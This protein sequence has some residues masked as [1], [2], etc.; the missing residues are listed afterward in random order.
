MGEYGS[1]LWTG[2]KALPP[3]AHLALVSFV[4]HMIYGGS[5]GYHHDEVYFAATGRRWE[6]GYVDNPPLVPW[7]GA[8]SE[9]LFGG[10]LR[11]LRLFPALATSAAI[12]LTGSLCRRLGG[13]TFAQGIAALAVLV[14]PVYLRTGNLLCIPAFE[15]LYWVAAS[16]LVVRIIDEERPRLWMWIGLIAGV[17]L[18]TKH[19]MLFF[20]FGLVIGLLMTPERKQFKSAWLWAGGAIA[21]LVFS[22]NLMWQIQN[23]W[24]TL[25]FI[26]G[27]NANTMS[28]ISKVEFLLGQLIYE[29]IFSAPIWIM[30]IVFF[31]TE[32]GRR[33]RD[34]GW[35]YITV[36]AFLLAVGSKIYYLAPAYLALFAGGAVQLEAWLNARSGRNLKPAFVALLVFGGL[37]LAP[38][39][40]PMLPIDMTDR[41]VKVATFGAIKNAHELTGDL[42][43]QFGWEELVQLTREAYDGIPDAE[44]DGTI[45]LTFS[46]AVASSIEF[47]DDELPPP[48]SGDMSYYL[49]GW[50]G[51]EPDTVLTVGISQET[52]DQIFEEVTVVSTFSHPHVN[53]WRNGTLIAIGRKPKLTMEALWPQIKDWD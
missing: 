18:M 38:V 20:G 7:I 36:L 4:A 10:A 27:L 50:G 44:R 28:D 22:P 17:G 52:L 51:K 42:H 29:N 5:F 39:S 9:W 15:P 31:F 19:T 41:Y 16:Y 26:R 49:W 14:A 34:L 32:S 2:F 25:E 1:K 8:I 53:P 30:G 46:R 33:Y 21:V 11:G 43:D 6:F 37:F 35:I 40:L 12:Y 45:I 24:P 3:Q 47:F 13:G 23:G 48:R